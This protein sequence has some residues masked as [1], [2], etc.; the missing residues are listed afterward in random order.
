M[1]FASARW[2]G[3]RAPQGCGLEELR[4]SAGVLLRRYPAVVDSVEKT[5][6]GKMGQVL[7][8]GQQTLQER[9]A[10]LRGRLN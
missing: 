5:Y 2:S 3:V 10:A 6:P 1:K 9:F 7:C 8:E 4:E